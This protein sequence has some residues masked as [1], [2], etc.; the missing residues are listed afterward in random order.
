MDE[1]TRRQITWV[2]SAVK[3]RQLRRVLGRQKQYTLWSAGGEVRRR[4]PRAGSGGSA[5]SRTAGAVFPHRVLR[6]SS[7]KL[8]QIQEESG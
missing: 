8:A 3:A 6:S 7:S 2:L 4:A 1:N 5:A